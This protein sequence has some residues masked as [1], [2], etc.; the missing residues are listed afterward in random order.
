LADFIDFKLR[1]AVNV[2]KS[3]HVRGFFFVYLSFVCF[4]E[5][6]THLDRF[7]CSINMNEMYPPE[8]DTV[9]KI[10][11][12]M[13]YLPIT[14]VGEFNSHVSLFSTMLIYCMWKSA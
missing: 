5:N 6:S 3:W 1:W 12:D 8:S 14:S 9:E 13:N 2:K 7:Y 4:S 11:N 10:I